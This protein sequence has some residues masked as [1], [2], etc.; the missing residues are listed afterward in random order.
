MPRWAK[1]YC[2]QPSFRIDCLHT[3]KQFLRIIG[4]DDQFFDIIYRRQKGDIAIPVGKIRRDD[5][6]SW[7]ELL[8]AYYVN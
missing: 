3:K 5:L 4:N 1:I 2:D 6:A 8:G 7:M